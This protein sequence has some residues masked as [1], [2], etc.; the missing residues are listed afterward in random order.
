MSSLLEPRD[1]EILR[2]L[3]RLRYLTTRQLTKAFFSHERL[4][5][6]R[7]QRLSRDGFLCFHTKGIPEYRHNG[8]WRI[9]QKGLE[10]V[11]DAFPE[12]HILE[13]LV[14]RVRYGS[15]R[16][17][18]ERIL[19]A[20]IYF[21]L[22]VWHARRV[23]NAS[24]V[25]EVRLWARAL[26]K[27]AAEFSW[28]PKA[29]V[30]LKYASLGKRGQVVPDATIASHAAC[31]RFFVMLDPRRRPAKWVTEPYD[32]L[33]RLRGFDGPADLGFGD[34]YA[35][36]FVIIAGRHRRMRTLKREL[37]NHHRCPM[38]FAVMHHES[39]G[40]WLRNAMVR[41]EEQVIH[42]G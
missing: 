30:I 32:G 22:T 3:V 11:A 42:V 10:E 26:A 38:P 2:T 13:N 1:L 24:H 5:R 19:L 4:G 37:D 28:R 20:A 21:E 6:R 8:A 25:M 7:L 23:W 17:L 16:D 33:A 40:A 35:P 34:G 12:E 36:T 18:H 14:D 27:R 39:A 15:L 31:R 41:S 9:T 29:D